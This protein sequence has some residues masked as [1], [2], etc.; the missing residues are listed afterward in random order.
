M[1]KGADTATVSAACRRIALEAAC[2]TPTI[3][4]NLISVEMHNCGSVRCSYYSEDGDEVMLIPDILSAQGTLLKATL[5]ASIVNDEIK[6]K[7]RGKTVKNGT[8]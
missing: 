7:L 4:R 2:H 5:S 3:S 6:I 8:L 1:K